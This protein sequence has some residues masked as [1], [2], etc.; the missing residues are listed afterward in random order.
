MPL[1][2]VT[3]S[4]DPETAEDVFEEIGSY[5]WVIFSS[6]NGVRY[7]FDLFHE[8][9]ADIRSLG[10]LRIAAVG[11][12][13]AA[14]VSGHRL[15]VDL[16]PVNADGESL[17]EALLNEQVMDNVKVLVVRGNLGRGVIV[18]RLEAAQA[19]VDV[20]PVYATEKTNLA[21]HPAARDFRCGGADAITFTS[22]SAVASFVSQAG[23]LQPEKGSVTPI[24]CSI[25]PVTS[26]AMREA[27]LPVDVEAVQ[28]SLD[29][30][31]DALVKRFP[32]ASED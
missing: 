4:V 14:A 7:F 25:G 9:F 27:G 2:T 26:L 30:I 21:E 10:F 31:V 32:H 1:V 17:V 8:K 24:T 11:Q 3:P 5:E 19:I 22:P 15:K 28:Q 20:F 29:G 13:T 18:E 23:A 6:S 12:A 16:I